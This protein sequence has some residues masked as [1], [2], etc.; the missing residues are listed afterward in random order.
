[1][2]ERFDQARLQIR[3]EAVGD[4]L[5]AE[6]I[7]DA[8]GVLVPLPRPSVVLELNLEDHHEQA[9]RDLCPSILGAAKRG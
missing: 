6:K 7:A 3:F 9:G 2:A 5:A 1:M 4:R 8:Y